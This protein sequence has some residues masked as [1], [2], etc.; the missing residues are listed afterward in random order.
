MLVCTSDRIFAAEPSRAVAAEAGQAGLPLR[1]R[2][3]VCRGPG[4]PAGVP[5]ERALHP[6]LPSAAVVSAGDGGRRA[7]EEPKGPRPGLGA[8]RGTPPVRDAD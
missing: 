6:G 5:A 2:G 4:V 8:G 3:G 7:E 1:D